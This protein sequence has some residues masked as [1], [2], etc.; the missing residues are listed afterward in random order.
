MTLDRIIK[1]KKSLQDFKFNI[2]NLQF[3][4]IGVKL[5]INYN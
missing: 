1:T 4:Y 3:K 5:K 2:R